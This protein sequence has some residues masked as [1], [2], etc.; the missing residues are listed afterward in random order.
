MALL[1]RNPKNV[2]EPDASEARQTIWSELKYR[3]FLI[4]ISL[5]L[6]LRIFLM[7][8]Y[9]PA[10][11][12]WIDSIRFA[13]ID[14]P[15]FFADFWMPA[16][17]PGLLM[18]LRAISH[19]LCFTIGV[20]HLMGLAVGPIFFLSMRR[21]SAPRWLAALAAA[22]PLL[23]GD[24][25]YLE[26]VVMADYLLIL[27]AAAGL[28]LAVWALSNGVEMRPLA[29]ASIFLALATLVRSVGV[30][31]LPVLVFCALVAAANSWRH[32]LGAAA[33]ALLPGLTVF[34]CYVFAFLVSHGAY[35][36]LSDMGG[37]N[38]YSRVA[39]F[40]DCRRFTPPLGT[41]E[42][43]E[44]TPMAQRPGPFGYVWDSNSVARRNFAFNVA[45]SKKMGRFAREAIL[46]QPW[47]YAS[48]VLSDLSRYI[49]PRIAS[50]RDYSGQSREIVSFGWRDRNL[51]RLV[52]DW[53]SKKYR[54]TKVH[55]RWPAV[56]AEYQNLFR[57]D[58]LPLAG[59]IVFTVLGMLR[60]G[61]PLRVG[62]LL[63]GLSALGLYLVPVLTVSYDFRYGI[64]GETFIVVSGLLGALAFARRKQKGETHAHE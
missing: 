3:P 14:P 28:G 57:L 43:C 63:F 53:M 9:R 24:H 12:L 2:P 16:G 41:A 17:Y 22:A 42:L 38:L 23:S 27:L 59:L 30:I 58:G 6:I 37:W 64:P 39:P 7:I 29:A 33:A 20:Q 13:R 54:G 50:G 45:D 47:A 10:V 56:L 31:L 32:R 26:H 60:A 46:H 51:E 62:I 49:D 8:A 55:L 1:K 4:L 15:Q 52:V 61:G 21:L 35:L 25:L 40:A 36:G 18:I 34:L 5:G 19:Q 11:M 44:A 48:A